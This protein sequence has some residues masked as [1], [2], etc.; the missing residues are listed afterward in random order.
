MSTDNMNTDKQI[1]AKMK[2]TF[3]TSPWDG[4]ISKEEALAQLICYRDGLS[5]EER[6]LYDE[7]ILR[8]HHPSNAAH[9]LELMRDTGMLPAAALASAD[10]K[11][12]ERIR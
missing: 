4:V 5:E 6:R 12:V 7:H 2:E 10:I 11:P 3:R 8:G 9:L 1:R